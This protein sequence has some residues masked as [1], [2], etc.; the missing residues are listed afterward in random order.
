MYEKASMKPAT[1]HNHFN[2]QAEDFII[3]H[4]VIYLVKEI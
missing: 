2:N 1:L 4:N 3:I